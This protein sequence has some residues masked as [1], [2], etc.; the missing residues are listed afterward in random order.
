MGIP[1]EWLVRRIDYRAHVQDMLAPIGDL[2]EETVHRVEGRVA[3]VEAKLLPGDEVWEWRYD[4]GDF[5]SAG[6]AAILRGG[7][8]IDE[9]REWV[10]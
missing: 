1:R 8:I 7:Q 9:W 5:S 4:G 6:G 3:A 2:P 10:S